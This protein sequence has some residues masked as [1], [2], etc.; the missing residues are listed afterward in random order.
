MVAEVTKPDFSYVWASGGAVVMPSNVKTQ[1]GWT[2]EVPPFQWENA[3][4]NRQD[5]AIVHLFQKGISVWDS[6]SNYYFTTGGVRSYVQGSDGN[7]YVA[8]QSSLG[9]N[10][11]TDLSNT[12]WKVA[13]ASPGAFITQAAGD[14]RYLQKAN[15][16]SDLSNP[17]TARTNLGLDTILQSGVGG[18]ASNLKL[19]A[20]GTNATVT[21]TANAICAK[22]A[23]NVQIILNNVSLTLSLTT[24]G[25]NG[26]D[27][28]TSTASTWYNVWAI[29]N[30]TVSAGLLSLSA[31]S[32]TMPSGYTYKALVG[33]IRTDST[34]N[35]YPLSFQQTGSSWQ[36]KVATGS[37]LLAMPTLASGI[38]G[39]PSVGPTWAA[40]AVGSFAPPS[41]SGITLVLSTTVAGA[42]AIIVAPNN[43]YG[44]YNSSTNPPP[45]GLSNGSFLPGPTQAKFQ[46]EG[47]NM[48][49]A[50]D[51]AE[52]R[53]YIT[54]FELNL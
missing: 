7:I 4:Q 54:S 39:N 30:G 50:A 18:V 26:L 14:I 36:Y 48:Y 16:L 15:N 35:K 47:P 25:A 32:P 3:L 11:V 13:F 49:W 6:G 1:T 44:T 37:N 20:S 12:Y 43:S 8:V 29:S 28:G 51:R 33:C 34:A 52:A 31:T 45:G 38:G 40:L 5:N 53:I 23:S 41:A 2:A 9:Q 22:N 17:A 27:T 24:V 21:L 10:P 42:T 46:L 19:S